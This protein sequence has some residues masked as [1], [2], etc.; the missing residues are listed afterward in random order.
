M[1]PA[2]RR[3]LHPVVRSLLGSGHE[4]SFFQAVRLLQAL[5][6]EA[7]R[8]G[9]QGPAADEVIRFSAELDLGFPTADVARV[10]EEE[11]ATPAGDA[12][13]EAPDRY[14]L[15][16]T[17]LGLYGTS[18]PLPASYTEDL[19][20]QE[21]DSL[22]RGFYDLFQHRLLSLLYRAWE[23]YRYAVRFRPDGSDY[24]SHRL[25]CLLHVQ[26]DHLP[27][28]HAVPG[29]QLLALAGL[30]SQEPRSA[31]SLEAA[32]RALLPAAEAWVEPFVARY[33]PIPADQQLQL[34]AGGPRLGE[35]TYLGTTILDRSS[36]FRLVVLAA[37]FDTYVRLLP[38]GDLLAP[39]RELVDLFNSDFL[40][41]QLE[42]RLAE[43]AVP[44]TRLGA[45]SALLGWSTWLGTPAPESRHVRILCEGAL[46][47]GR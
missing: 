20:Q 10:S 34:G 43:D 47:G 5:Y 37:D 8:V 2:L 46:H 35:E 22:E 1:A 6:P 38:G 44:E 45:A 9:E 28:E 18:S 13:A 7:A 41:C 24:Y 25:A 39:L 3:S 12:A 14:R 30:L 26:R 42:V 4:Y 32:A 40:D 21:P 23:R 27:D 17:F 29:L 33:L 36:T 16:A 19:L 31:A 11:P 15:F